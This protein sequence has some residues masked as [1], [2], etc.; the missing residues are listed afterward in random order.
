M[1]RINDIASYSQAKRDGLDVRRRH[2]DLLLWFGPFLL[3]AFNH[4]NVNADTKNNN[5]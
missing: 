3:K 2:K 4:L 1:Q 5:R